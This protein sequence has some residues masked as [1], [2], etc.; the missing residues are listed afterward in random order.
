MIRTLHF[1]SGAAVIGWSPFVDVAVRDAVDVQGEILVIVGTVSIAIVVGGEQGKVLLLLLLL[2]L[3]IM[4]VQEEEESV[5]SS[6]I[7]VVKVRR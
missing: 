5:S 2:L 3:I 6:F 4:A 7:V 1:C